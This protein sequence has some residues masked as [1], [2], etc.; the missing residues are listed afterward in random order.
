MYFNQAKTK[1][2]RKNQDARIALLAIEAIPPSQRKSF[3]A[4]VD[5]YNIMHVILL[6]TLAVATARQRER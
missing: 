5:I 1:F 4:V 6:L 3:F 2:V